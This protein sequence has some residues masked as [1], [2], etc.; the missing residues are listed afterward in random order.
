M[1]HLPELIYDLGLI[2]ITGAVTTLIFRKIKQP[3]VLG[4]IL[5]GF[6]VGPYTPIIPTVTDSEGIKTWSEIGVIFL[7]F[8][9]GLEFSFKKL[10]K[11][12]GSAS[13]T[14]VT[15]IIIMIIVGYIA[16]QFLGW[17]VMD[18]IF[19]GAILSMS[20]TTIIIRAFDEVGAKTQKFASLVFGVLIVED[21]VAILLMVVLST[22]AVSNEFAGGEL[23]IQLFKLFFFL[24]A[25]FL[26]GIFFIPTFLKY[27]QKLMTDE[28]LLIV[29]LGLCLLMVIF[30]VNVGFSAAL[31]A[32][33]MG[34]ILAETTKAEQ[35]EHLIKSVKD[36]FA[37]IFFIS[38]GMMINPQIL[39]DY[40]VP[41]LIVTLLTIFGKFF[42][43]TAGALLSGQPLKHSVQAGM[44]LA[45]IGEFSFIIATLGLS[46]KV[47]S[48][49][50]Y[51]ITVAAST[52]T[53]LT[54]PFLI[55]RSESF[56]LLLEKILP[57]RMID[58][59]N[60]YSSASQ[61][62]TAYSDWKKLLRSYIFN[63]VVHS[64]V[65]ISIILLSKNFLYPF[66]V[67]SL[68]SGFT[69]S[70]ITTIITILFLIGPI[71][72]LALRRINK[73]AYKNLW[74]ERKLN[75][76][77]LIAIEIVRIALAILLLGFLLETYFSTVI[78]LIIS[79]ISIAVV[80]LIFSRSLQR[81]YDR[82]ETRFYD[83]LN[84]REAA[85]KRYQN[86]VPWDAHF[87]RFTVHPDLPVVGKSLLE[88]AFREKYGVNI[89]LIRR[90]SKRLVAPNRNERLFPGDRLLVIGTDDQLNKFSEVFIPETKEEDTEVEVILKNFKVE[91]MC[92]LY[93]N[94][95]SSLS[96]QDKEEILIV[97][98]ERN[99]SRIL[100]PDSNLRILPED[101]IWAIGTPEKLNAF[102]GQTD[103]AKQK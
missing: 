18:S 73:Q 88:L 19:L 11:V 62:I 16:G 77:P 15:E 81:F 53:T 27:T 23:T 22:I 2:L 51:P 102:I 64:V 35:I 95:L 45:Q 94:S 7:L 66:V 21:L 84:E 72:A 61:Q 70:L 46:L 9:L 74:L 3:L 87:A 82:I 63:I 13:V 54:T 28:T 4:Y 47:T 14:A 67:D 85:N 56:Y 100:N 44:S 99:G 37:A 32:F 50:L 89:A 30:S 41:V 76:S 65:A 59:F 98:I 20:S 42:A 17:S 69:S 33:I 49:F 38:V 58:F 1:G 40:A 10:V 103:N 26:A 25:W 39:V 55:K 48:D 96:I 91:P 75:R 12:G 31:G 80:S 78:A 29:S 60:R 92:S 90:G 5:A 97:G 36:L 52:V 57:Q 86:I 6:L 83:N 34:S 43:S 79:S 24:I 93:N 101:I 8:S 68:G 71:W